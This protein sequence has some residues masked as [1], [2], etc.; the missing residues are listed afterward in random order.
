MK[1]FIV[2]P[3][4]ENI[5]NITY[6]QLFG[7]LENG[8]SFVT[9]NKFQPYFYIKA[10]DLKKCK[11]TIAKE[12]AETQDTN[13]TDFKKE[14]VIKI[15]SLNQEQQNKL[16]KEL[17]EAGIKTYE[18]DIKP[19]FR[20]MFDKDILGHIEIDGEYELGERVNKIYRNPDI[21]PVKESNKKP[22]KLKIASIDIESS[23]DANS[24]YCIG[25][26]SN[27][28]GKEYKK[29]F[30]V[31]NKKLDHTISCKDEEECLEKFKQELIDMD[32][33]IITGWNLIDFDFALLKKLFE[34]HKIKFDLGRNNNNS[35]LRVEENFFRNSTMDISGRLVLDGLNFIR[36]P[37]IKEAP[38]IKNTKFDNYTLEEV[39]QQILK[40][41]KLIKGKQRHHEI[42]ELYEGNKEEQQKLAD[43]NLMDC[44]LV[45]D[46]LEKT[47]MIELAIERSE[48]T[49]MP[50]DRIGGSIANFDSLYIREA[51]KKNLVSPTTTFSNKEERIKGGFVMTPKSGL[52]HNVLV[53]DFKSLYPSIIKTFNI[54]PSSFVDSKSLEKNQ[55]Y[56]K[57]PNNA[58]FKNQEGILPQIISRLHDA[59][60]KAKREKRELSSY[61]VKIMMNCFSP[62]TEVLTETGLKNVR[63]VEVGER[64]YSIDLRGNIELKSVTK[65][66]FYP[67]KGKMIKIKTNV[68]DY[69]VTPNHR[70][71]IDFGNGYEWKE[72][73]ELLNL[74]KDFW[75]PKHKKISGGKIGRINLED[76]CKKYN[77]IYR[78]KGEKLQAGRKH[79]SINA[80]YNMKE[81]LEFIGWY[82]SEGHI[83]TSKPRHYKNKAS[84]RGV[85]KV[86]M[87]NQK[88]E[89]NRGKIEALLTKMGLKYCKQINGIS[90]NNHILANILE[91]ECGL[92]SRSKKIPNWIYKLEPKL[93]EKLF[94][95]MMLGDGDKNGE[96]YSTNSPRLAKD[97]L[98]V[99][100]HLGLYGFVYK[101]K[102][103]YKG[104]DYIMFRV[105]VNK[106][107]GI[108]PYISPKRNMSYENFEG[109][110]SCIEVPPYH[111]ILAGRN[112]RLNFCG[113]S[114]FGVLASPNSR[115]F[116]LTMANAITNFGQEIIKLTAKEIE[117]LGYDVIYSDTDSVFVHTKLNKQEAEKLGQEISNHIDKFY[118]VYVKENYNRKSYLDLEF[119]KLFISL[120][121]PRLRVKEKSEKSKTQEESKDSIVKGAKKRYAGLVEETEHGKTKAVLE[122]TGLEAIRGDWTEAAQEFQKELLMKV[123]KNENPSS[124]IKQFVKDLNSGKLDKKLVYRKSIRKDL[125][126]YT[127][128]TPPHVKAAR[129][130]DKIESNIIEYYI[131]TN[132]PEP[133]QKL[134]HHLD[135]KHYIEKQ[136]EPI[137]RT[138]LETISIDFKQLIEGSKQ[139]TLF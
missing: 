131:T 6:V 85:T 1:G 90:I 93:L 92:G 10:A 63:E 22:V 21:T 77:L 64:V 35:R 73:Q 79:S 41:T 120:I 66:F 125:K 24:L 38:S 138:I 48:L 27:I 46:I 78:K 47:K 97:F 133:I 31:T 113:Q 61:A 3:S 110:V 50:L 116:D 126:E 107:R 76:F 122:I 137:A 130:L 37:F 55:E 49:G 81:W 34:K 129:L 33:D 132:G 18:S 51:N 65:R 42:Q 108:R 12:K 114:F 56:I 96:R 39:S 88:I 80:S 115:Y 26:Y 45:Y 100:H 29:N 28:Q 36:D 70:F 8:E 68:V 123:L 44:Q 4:Y 86:V 134:K 57:S 94:G 25:I 43:Y 135:Y 20:F 121:M 95:S 59:R 119:D 102:F 13:K 74:K 23:G 112:T 5:D 83:Y 40:R 105:Q 99:L 139:K 58:H 72:A 124:F 2:Y 136:I 101:D 52:Y 75:L 109:N 106:K 103:K 19:H 128:T 87:I 7:R 111:T 62:D 15:I 54:D 91:K 89:E 69:L 98:R 32:P 60:E 9:L 16:S 30:M 71:L 17:H 11:R 118:N 104:E 84:W 14:K 67:Y 53:L 117:K 82:L 127:K